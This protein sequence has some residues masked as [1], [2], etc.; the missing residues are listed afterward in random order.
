MNDGGWRIVT[1]IISGL[2]LLG[3]LALLYFHKHPDLLKKYRMKSEGEIN[4]TPVSHVPLSF[5]RPLMSIAGH[6]RISG[7]VMRPTI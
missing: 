7:T 1:S 3:V 6:S 2:L 5:D 4:M